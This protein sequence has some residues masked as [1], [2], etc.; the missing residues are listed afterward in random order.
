MTFL[1]ELV[2]YLV[3][4]PVKTRMTTP[5]SS[6]EYALWLGC[7]SCLPTVFYGHFV[8]SSSCSIMSGWVNPVCI[9]GVRYWHSAHLLTANMFLM[10]EV[11]LPVLHFLYID[12]LPL[13]FNEQEFS[14]KIRRIFVIYILRRGELK[15]HVCVC[16]HTHPC[17]NIGDAYGCTHT[18]SFMC[19]CMHLC[20]FLHAL[21]SM[22]LCT[23]HV[24]WS[25]L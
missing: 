14:R 20:V 24:C 2:L 13:V 7:E 16:V 19:T 18:Y 15:V 9:Q 12:L 21:V 8:N 11:P 23:L 22:C 6:V 1:D 17:A 25:V 10:N 5:I 4:A 3:L